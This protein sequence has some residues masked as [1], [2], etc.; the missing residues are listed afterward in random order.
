MSH[1][2]L[3]EFLLV[4]LTHNAVAVFCKCRCCLPVVC[5]ASSLVLVEMLQ[6]YVGR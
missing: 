6:L 2:S 3:F 5:C 4:F 1:A